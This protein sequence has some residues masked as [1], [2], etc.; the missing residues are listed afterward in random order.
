MPAFQV[1]PNP[2]EEPAF[3]EG[4]EAAG[5]L[6]RLD[7]SEARITARYQHA[8]NKMQFAAHSEEFL[9]RAGVRK[10]HGSTVQFFNEDPVSD[11]FVHVMVGSLPSN[12]Q[13][14]VTPHQLAT[15]GWTPIGSPDEADGTMHFTVSHPGFWPITV[16]F[17]S[18]PSDM[19][20]EDRFALADEGYVSSDSQAH[21]RSARGSSRRRRS[22]RSRRAAAYDSSS[23]SEDEEDA[24][25]FR[26]AASAG[27]YRSGR[28][29]YAGGSGGGRASR[30]G[31]QRRMSSYASDDAGYSSAARG[32]AGYGSTGDYAG[33]GI[34][35]SSS[36]ARSSRSARY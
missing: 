15:S 28:D 10:V 23:G 7:T 13:A 29:D 1:E 33:A 24:G 25:G 2:F 17:D 9:T 19:G 22:S 14:L 32:G 3:L 11:P 34:P 35:R 26:R 31:S 4:L 18:N 8:L 27:G 16:V 30:A 6:Q 20:R 5:Y 21:L 12:R 36:R